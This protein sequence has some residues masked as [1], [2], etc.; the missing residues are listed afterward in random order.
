M[1][2]AEQA[3]SRVSEEQQ[4]CPASAARRRFLAALRMTRGGFPSRP[5]SLSPPGDPVHPP[6]T[7]EASETS[8]VWTQQFRGNGAPFGGTPLEEPSL[9]V[10][11]AYLGRRLSAGYSRLWSRGPQIHHAALSPASRDQSSSALA[12][13]P[14]VY[15][16]PAPPWRD[17]SLGATSAM[18][19]RPACGCKA[20]LFE[21][22]TAAGGSPCELRLHC[23]TT[24]R[25]EPMRHDHRSP[26]RKS[27][28][29]RRS[30][31]EILR[32]AENERG[33][34]LLAPLVPPAA[35]LRMTRPRGVSTRG[36]AGCEPVD[37]VT[38]QV[39]DVD[40]EGAM[41]A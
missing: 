4:D 40:V 34:Q 30:A 22:E 7:S 33:G 3:R 2:M 18:Q 16:A 9:R 38:V 17:L 32:C 19:Q 26:V 27:L 10:P 5:S 14:S 1:P 13:S 36:G 39:K 15:I 41:P 31:A 8:E 23:S 20:S 25:Q 35:W 6:K 28:L 12:R 21:V 11:N 37:S 24:R 29:R